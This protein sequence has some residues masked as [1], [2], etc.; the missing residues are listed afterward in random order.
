[1][2][3][4]LE[5]IQHNMDV[6][7]Q[8]FQSIND[9]YDLDNIAVLCKSFNQVLNA[10]A[11]GRLLWLNLAIQT[12]CGAPG[13]LCNQSDGYNPEQ[14]RRHFSQING[15]K[16]FFW[17]LRL[18]VCPWHAA[19]VELPFSVRDGEFWFEKRFL[20]FE[21]EADC[22]R[23]RF[24]AETRDES[25]AFS[26]P[27]RPVEHFD[28]Q[29][30]GDLEWVTPPSNPSMYESLAQEVAEKKVIP[31]FSHE[32]RCEYRFYPIHAGVFAVVEVFSLIF[33]NDDLVDHGIYFLS[34]VNRRVLRHIRFDDILCLERCCI[35][36][37]PFE[38]WMMTGRRLMYHGPSCDPRSDENWD[39]E[40]MDEALWMAG[41][42][43]ALG[44]IEHMKFM[45]IDLNTQSLI[46]SRTLLHYAAKEGHVQAVRDLLNAGFTAVDY[47]DDFDHSALLMAAA[48]LHL[49]VVEILLKEGRADPLIGESILTYIGDFVQYRPYSA[50]VDRTRDE[51]SRLVPSIVRL[52]VDADHR[53]VTVSEHCMNQPSI[54]SSP[55]AVRIVCSVDQEDR[56]LLCEIVT[57]FGHFRNLFQELS[58]VESLY[59]LVREFDFDV[60]QVD[61]HFVDPA[62][63]VLARS[64]IA[65]SVISMLDTLGADVA[66]MDSKGKS[67]RQIAQERASRQ[68]ADPEGR[69]IL[70]F[71]DLRGL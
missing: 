62:V 34:H 45:G 31:D 15:R 24:Q 51:I 19:G 71:L 29:V 1:M 9:L 7:F 11:R 5:L 26:F 37:R 8:I 68:P 57:T 16:D 47:T 55:E 64:G 58:A 30:R 25:R 40:K 56:P 53:V 65:E 33:D 22:S 14:I 50:L 36:S 46:S 39:S 6:S 35:L 10:T 49:D 44:A 43:N 42:G 28:E 38:L 2:S 13:E 54:L 20:F 60:N 59:V 32:R 48:E 17:H 61:E 27:A 4:F 3:H 69:R 70:D 63:I 66:A 41:R 12:T 23:L 21:D 52:L 67:I 18:L